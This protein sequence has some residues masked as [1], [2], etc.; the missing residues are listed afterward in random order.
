M[1]L[2]SCLAQ[3][4]EN[5]EA[6][7]IDDHS[8][9]DIKSITD[10]FLDQRIRY[11]RQSKDKQGIAAA[12]QTAIEN[13]HSQIYIT[14]DSD[15]I[16]MPNRAYR[17]KQLLSGPT[18]KLIYTRVRFFDDK[19][20]SD[21]KKPVLEPHNKELLQAFNYIT[22]PG[23]AFNKKAYRL[24]GCYYDLEMEICE[25]YE[26]YLRMSDAGVDIQ[27]VDEEHVFY[28]KNA[29]SATANCKQKIK[30]FVD[31]IRLKNG[32]EDISMQTLKKFASPALW[33][34]IKN[35]P[36][37]QWIWFGVADDAKH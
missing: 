6:V 7:V 33:E 28:R 9:C 35:D 18:A 5:W 2:A 15:D 19:S 31:K 12:R 37:S 14:L 4:Y 26:L 22:N 36:E 32:L 3:T 17:C 27:A 20:G 16:S 29:A 13:A 21:H 1:A 10:Y 11:I 23:T 25:D 24:A 30:F 34:S 8:S